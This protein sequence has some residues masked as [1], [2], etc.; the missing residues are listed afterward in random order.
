LLK[1]AIQW[2]RQFI[3]ISEE[4]EKIIMESK[5]SL[6]FRNGKPW[7]KRGNP[8]FDIGQGSYDGAETCELIGLYILSELVKL[9]IDVG[10]YRDDGLAVTSA[11]PK[12]VENIKKKISEIFRKNKLEVTI[13]ANLKTV[14][15]L[16]ITMELQ[17]DTFRP[18]IKPN[19]VPLYIH[20]QSNHPPTVIKNIPD[21]IN[22]RLSKISCNETVFNEAAPAYQ[23]AL[24]KSGYIH[25]LKFDPEAGNPKSNGRNRKRKI[26]W[27][28]PPFNLNTKTNIGKYS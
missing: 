13:D 12:Q 27:F 10:L 24:E 26:C 19:T 1:A 15:F 16:D 2:A 17:T 14:D 8:D 11:T 18:F 9:N 25:K 5:K 21:A 28:N 22:K 7:C 4:Q 3:E 23:E 6:I 20:T